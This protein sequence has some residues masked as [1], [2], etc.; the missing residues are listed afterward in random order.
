MGLET[1]GRRGLPFAFGLVGGEVGMGEV[2]GMGLEMDE[3]EGLARC[4]LEKRRDALVRHMRG[5]DR[6]GPI[7][8]WQWK[9]THSASLDLTSLGQCGWP[10]GR[11]EERRMEDGGRW[12]EDYGRLGRR[13]DMWIARMRNILLL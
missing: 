8:G 2:T 1:D 4:E 12:V 11:G 3:M 9:N 5:Q 10:V 6:L 13:R 7:S